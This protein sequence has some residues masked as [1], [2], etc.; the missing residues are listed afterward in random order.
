MFDADDETMT[1][2]RI[3]IRRVVTVSAYAQ[4]GEAP[5]TKVIRQG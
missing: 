3:G 5:F 1:R 2:R 4:T